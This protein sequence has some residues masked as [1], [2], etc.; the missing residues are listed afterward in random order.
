MLV[1]SI[2]IV[3]ILVVLGIVA[4]VK[5]WNNR[6]EMKPAETN[7]RIVFVLGAILFLVGLAFMIVFFFTDIPLAI[8]IPPFIIGITYLATAWA[9]R[10]KWKPRV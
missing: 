5:V 2:A 7:Y 8:G 3:A 10:D 4:G 9:N 6:K 1:A